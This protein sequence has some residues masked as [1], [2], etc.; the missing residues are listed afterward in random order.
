M[1]V[2]FYDGNWIE[3]GT[4]SSLEKLIS[5]ITGIRNISRW[6]EAS[7]RQKMSREFAQFLVN[8]SA[9]WGRYAKSNFVCRN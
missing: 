3:I 7:R 2:V 1:T 6:E 8:S 5:I 9:R 4:K